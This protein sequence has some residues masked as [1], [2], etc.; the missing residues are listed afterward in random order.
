MTHTCLICAH[1]S[2]GL[3]FCFKDARTDFITGRKICNIMIYYKRWK[4]ITVQ[5]EKYLGF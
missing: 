1:F 4:S 5:V 2:D 3:F